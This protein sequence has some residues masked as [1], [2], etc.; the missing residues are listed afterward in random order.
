[1]KKL[2]AFVLA[3]VLLCGSL[4]ACGGSR[5]HPTGQMKNYVWEQ[6]PEP[7][8]NF[9]ANAHYDPTNYKVSVIG[10]YA[11]AEPD[12]TNE[13]PIGVTL[14]VGDGALEVN[15]KYVTVTDGAAKIYNLI[16]NVSTP[17]TITDKNGDIVY[18]GT[19]KPTHFLR[20]IMC[21]EARNAR[22]LG[23]WKCDGGT[24]AYGKIIRGGVP[25]EADRGVLVDELGIEVDIELRGLND[26][27]WLPPEHSK[28]GEDITYYVFDRYAWYSLSDKE[29]WT[30][31]LRAVFDTVLADKPLYL[32]CGAGADRTGTAVCVIEALLGMSQSDIDMDYEM[33]SFFTGGDDARN[34]RRNNTEGWGVLIS[35][36]RAREGT[37]FRDKAVQFVLD[38]GFSLDEINAFRRKMIR[39]NPAALKAE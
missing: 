22:D 34:R 23:G 15:G 3:A 6:T 14:D 11:P 38:L 13:Q 25:H 16:P 17:Y 32:H 18:T 1:M 12:I 8:R 39:G 35:Q 37:T 20:Q 2:L 30:E 31:I 29:L 24:V 27:D 33:T 36:I 10:D 19:L 28:L 9:L 21:P 5:V 4:T 26:K 7:V